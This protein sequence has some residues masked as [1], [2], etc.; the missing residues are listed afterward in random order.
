[1][2]STGRLYLSAFSSDLLVQ[3]LID[4]RRT[5]VPPGTPTRIPVERDETA[6]VFSLVVALLSLLLLERSCELTGGP[7][8]SDVCFSTSQLFPVRCTLCE[9][10]S[11][12]SFYVFV[13]CLYVFVAG[14]RWSVSVRVDGY[15]VRGGC[16]VR[17]RVRVVPG[18]FVSKRTNAANLQVG[19]ELR[20]ESSVRLLRV[21]GRGHGSDTRVGGLLGTDSVAFLYLPSRTTGRT[22]T[23]LS[24]SGGRAGVVSTSATREA[25]PN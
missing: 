18:M 15:V 19:D 1:M 24:G 2:H 11:G 25:T 16:A 8:G 4:F 20:R 22:T 13:R 17:S 14:L 7:G 12:C 10:W 21:S 6:V 23:L 9:T 3:W 5:G